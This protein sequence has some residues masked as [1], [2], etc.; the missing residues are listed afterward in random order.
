MKGKRI[1]AA[2]AAMT[3]AGVV[4]AA[5]LAAAPCVQ[6]HADGNVFSAK[7]P[8]VAQARTLD[9]CL[10]CHGKTAPVLSVLLHSRHS[11]KVPCTACHELKDGKLFVKAMKAPLGD[12]S[13]DLFSLYEE[14]YEPDIKGAAKLHEAYKLSCVSCHGVKTPAEGA[15]V[16]NSTCEKC[17]GSQAEIAK[18]TVPKIKEQNPHASHQ[19]KLACSKCHKGHDTPTSYCLECHNNF[20][21]KMPEADFFK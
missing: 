3:A 12:V 20:E 2:L 18:R 17:H 21:Q 4:S 8:P 19:G 1:F 16:E 6:C 9:D 7:H 10:M 11:A 14:L 13:E 15:V 5:T